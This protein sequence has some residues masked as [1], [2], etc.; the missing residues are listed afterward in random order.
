[1]DSKPTTKAIM[2]LSIYRFKI[3][4]YT[5]DNIKTNI[6]RHSTDRRNQ[7]G[8]ILLIGCAVDCTSVIHSHVVPNFS[9]CFFTDSLL[10]ACLPNKITRL[11]P[12]YTAYLLLIKI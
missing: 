2:K 1:M 8:L 6:S 9:W 12:Y 10:G 3:L 11:L 7:K 5:Y 4:T